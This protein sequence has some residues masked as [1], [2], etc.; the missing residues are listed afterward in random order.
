MNI[1]RTD[2]I[3]IATTCLLF[4]ILAASTFLTGCASTTSTGTVTTD[5]ISSMTPKQKAI[6]FGTFYKSQYDSYK[7]RQDTAMTGAELQVM[8]ARWQILTALKPLLDSY[9]A[10]VESGTVPPADI[11]AKIL[12]LYA[13]LT[14][15]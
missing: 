15:N 6:F 8:K 5:G 10:Y 14:T 11:L 2:K 3:I 7:S 13:K 12:D 4:L 1:H 9:N